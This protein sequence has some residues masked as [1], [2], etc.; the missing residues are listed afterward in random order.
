MYSLQKY[1]S[2]PGLFFIC[3][4][5]NAKGNFYSQA[6]YKGFFSIAEGVLDSTAHNNYKYLHVYLSNSKYNSN[7][8]L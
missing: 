8:L 2:L 7:L 1:M 5:Y 4:H 3:V 6:Q